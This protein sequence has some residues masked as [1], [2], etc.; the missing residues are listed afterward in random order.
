VLALDG[1][2]G[3]EV[4]E[5]GSRCRFWHP[6]ADYRHF[7]HDI[8]EAPRPLLKKRHADGK[9]CAVQPS[10]AVIRDYSAGDLESIDST[11]KRLL[12]PHVY[13]VSI[14]EKLRSLKLDLIGNKG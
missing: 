6:S 11:C 7:Y 4:L 10:L 8:K 5:P 9:P 13:K 2:E 3:A 1:C 14:T 12:N